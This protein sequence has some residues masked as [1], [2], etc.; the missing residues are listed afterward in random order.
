MAPCSA[1]KQ[2]RRPQP[3]TRQDR[4]E[5]GDVTPVRHVVEAA[6]EAVDLP[7]GDQAV[8]ACRERV[9]T[10]GAQEERPQEERPEADGGY[11]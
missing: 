6:A 1:A 8:E 2:N 4:V 9:R 5:K 10:V 3:I 7:G 11:L